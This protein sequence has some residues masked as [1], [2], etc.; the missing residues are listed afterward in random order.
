MKLQKPDTPVVARMS[1]KPDYPPLLG[2][3]YHLFDLPSL[4]RL[5]VGRFPN[6]SSRAVIYRKFTYLHEDLTRMIFLDRHAILADDCRYPPDLRHARAPPLRAPTR[7]ADPARR[8][9]DAT[10]K[11]EAKSENEPKPQRLSGAWAPPVHSARANSRTGPTAPGC[12]HSRTRVAKRTQAPRH[13]STARGTTPSG[14]LPPPRPSPPPER[15]RPNLTPRSTRDPPNEPD[16]PVHPTR[17]RRTNPS[18]SLPC[19]L[20]SART[21]SATRCLGV[22]VRTQDPGRPAARKNEPDRPAIPRQAQER[23]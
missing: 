10:R 13:P 9:G 22:H 20:P 23:P 14:C 17:T 2:P 5:C 19:S 8:L 1:Q 15:T 12:T 6:S 11:P 7:C 18:T 4:E 16:R 3:G 21:P